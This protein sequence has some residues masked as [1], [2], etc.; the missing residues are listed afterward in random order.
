MKGIESVVII[1]MGALG[2]MYGDFF[3]EKGVE[4]SFLV[5]RKRVERYSSQVTRANGRERRF[6]LLSADEKQESA[7]LVIFAVKGTDLDEAVMEARSVVGPGTVLLSVMNGIISEEVIGKAFSVSQVV[8]CIVQ[9]MD[10]VKIGTDLEYSHFG[11][12]YIGAERSEQRE[13]LD[14][15]VDFLERTG[16]TY[17]VEKD[18]IHRIWTKWMLNV[19]VNQTVMLFE[20][21]YGSVQKPGEARDM[22]GALMR[23]VLSLA[24]ASNVALTES[25]Y[26]D[27]FALVDTLDPEKMPSMRQDGLMRRPSEVELF[28]GTVVLKAETLGLDV[29]YNRMVLD[30]VRK[31]EESY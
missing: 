18:I 2:V 12:I 13:A 11:R 28:A 6:R 16:L 30:R 27:M 5:D 31:L 29:P 26:D 25:D 4:V 23:E 3:L 15:L 8:P 20:G 17:I 14:R 9:G 1:G 24:R 21:N 10:A 22:M 19:G 7:D